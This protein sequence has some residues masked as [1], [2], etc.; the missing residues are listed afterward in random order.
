LGLAGGNWSVIFCRQ[1]SRSPTPLGGKKSLFGFG[2]CGLGWGWLVAGATSLFAAR[3]GRMVSAP[4][5]G[6][7]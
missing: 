1:R 6:G 3:R 4:T 7:I 2:G 5:F